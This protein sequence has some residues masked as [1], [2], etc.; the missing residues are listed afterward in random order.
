MIAFC[1]CDRPFSD[2]RGW[3][4]N[5]GG[6]LGED[7]RDKEISDLRT[8]IADLEAERDAARAGEARAVE[9]LDVFARAYRV[10]MLPFAPGIDE[11]DG[12]YHWMP[13]GW[14]SVG[15]FKLANSVL[16]GSSALSWL[17]QQRREAAVRAV[18]ALKGVSEAGWLPDMEEVI[19][20]ADCTCDFCDQNRLLETIEQVLSDDAQ[21]ALDWLAQRERE[22]AAMMRS[23]PAVEW[24]TEGGAF[25]NGLYL[26]AGPVVS[27]G[28]FSLVLKG[29]ERLYMNWHPTLE[30]AQAAAVAW[31]EE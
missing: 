26:W 29:K 18:E 20:C 24:H 30:A 11:A 1:E 17:A 23:R 28:F 7:E 16:S 10:S 6:R 2:S 15:D 25:K 13:H 27:G 21:P 19:H 3:C 9:A 12:A 22:A 14:P 4:S 31:I 8:R 5:C